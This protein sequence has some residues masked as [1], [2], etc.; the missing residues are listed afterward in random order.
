MVAA[1]AAALALVLPYTDAARSSEEDVC[2]HS[3]SAEE[4]HD[5]IK[6][7]APFSFFRSFLL[8]LILLRRQQEISP[9][10]VCLWESAE[11]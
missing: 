11:R 1:A 10:V 7:G 9:F 3:Y 6:L 2:P 5:E 4:A 8:L